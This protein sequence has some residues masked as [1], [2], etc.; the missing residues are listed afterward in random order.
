[1]S[2]SEKRDQTV[3]CWLLFCC[4]GER[5]GRKYNWLKMVCTIACGLFLPT[6]YLLLV[7]IRWKES[8]QG[9][10]LAVWASRCD[11]PLYQVYTDH[12]VVFYKKRRAR[13]VFG[14]G[15]GMVWRKGGASAGPCWGIPSPEVPAKMQCQ[16]TSFVNMKLG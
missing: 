12:I 4:L 11:T 7:D 5:I 9:Q 6:Y 16:H 8:S 10:V 1:M 15:Q 13:N 3:S 2:A 14:G